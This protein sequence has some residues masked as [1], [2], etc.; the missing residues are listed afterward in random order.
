MT[1]SAPVADIAHSLKAVAGLDE[2]LDSGLC[3]DLD[4]D[5]VDA[6]LE[7]AGKFANEQLAPLNRQGDLEGASLVDGEVRMPK[8]W[9]EVY[10]Q[11]IE[12]G[13]GGVP[14]PEDFGGQ[15]L[16][17]LLSMAVGEMWQSACMAFSLNPMLTQGAAEALS[18]HG[19]DELKAL[20]LPKMITG[21]WSGTMQ[22]TEPHAGSD[23][24]LLKCKAVPQEDGTYSL[25]GTKIFIT[26][27]DHDLAE[28]I[29]HMVLARTPDAPPGTKGISLFLVPKYLVNDDGSLGA[30]NDIVC[31]AVEHKLGIHASPTCVMQMGDAGGAKGWLIGAENEGL[32]TM[33]FMMNPR[34][35]RGR[36]PGRRHCR[37]CL[38]G[39]ACLCPGAQTGRRGPGARR[40]HGGDHP[41]SRC[42][43]HAHDHEGKDGG[44]ARHL[45]CHGACHR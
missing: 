4:A 38:S 8:G 29:V 32:K 14:C 16:P 19:R 23:L 33:F 34:P 1:Y 39:R 41:A 13:W 26:Y 45:L 11:W 30:R 37:A 25:S 18:L 2:L 24:R 44:R 27:G 35:A 7:E 6:I 10:Q 12:A 31:T 9:S 5:V 36:H 15:G 20:Y 42:S 28:N 21:E 22:L 43:A 40:R 3:G 17:V